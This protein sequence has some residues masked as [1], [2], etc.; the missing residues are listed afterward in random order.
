MRDIEIYNELAKT[1]LENAPVEA[2]IV[3][4][5][6]VVQVDMSLEEDGFYKFYFDYVN[7]NGEEQWFGIDKTGVPS[8]L[9][10]LSL[11]LRKEMIEG[12]QGKWKEFVFSINIK[13]EK[14]S[15]DFSY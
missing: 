14:F 1:L 15:A 10:E 5:R 9:T 6:F 8:V 7:N 4:M 11:E 3:K 13:E 12:E 2:V